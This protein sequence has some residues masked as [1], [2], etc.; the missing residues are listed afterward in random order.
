MPHRGVGGMRVKELDLDK[1]MA[2]PVSTRAYMAGFF[3]GE[4]HI[5]IARRG[6]VRTSRTDPSKTKV[7][8]AL[9]AG[10]AQNVKAPLELFHNTFGG[11]FR[12]DTRTRADR[13]SK[14][15]TYEW[16]IGGNLQVPIFLRWLRPY[17]LV[18]ATQADIAI[19]F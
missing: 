7:V 1:L 17:L 16:N 3:D 2:V 14:H 10:A 9:V 15:V 5:S 18:K 12:I 4:G 11:T 13:F 6:S 8:Y 19:E